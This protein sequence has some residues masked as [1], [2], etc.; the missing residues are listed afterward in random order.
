MRKEIAENKRR[1]QQILARRAQ[2]V[3]AQKVLARQAQKE[4]ETKRLQE[5]REMLGFGELSSSAKPT[6]YVDPNKGTKW[7]GKDTGLGPF[8]RAEQEK[9]PEVPNSAAVPECL[10][11]TW[12]HSARRYGI[13]IGR[14]NAS[15]QDTSG[16]SYCAN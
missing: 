2:K 9:R 13:K 10:D 12:E 16:F 5:A 6:G 15:E 3:L 4:K 7:E 8:F 11:S 14:S 1:A